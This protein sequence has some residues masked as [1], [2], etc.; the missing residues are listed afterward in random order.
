MVVAQRAGV[1]LHNEAVVHRHASDLDKQVP[2]EGPLVLVCR[3][4]T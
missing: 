2:L 4:A 1:G 3:S